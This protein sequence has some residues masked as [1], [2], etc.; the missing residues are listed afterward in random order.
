MVRMKWIRK[1]LLSL[2]VLGLMGWLAQPVSAQVLEEDEDSYLQRGFFFSVEYGPYFFV[3]RGRLSNVDLR[4]PQANIVG[5][6]GGVQI[7]YGITQHFSLEFLFLTTQMPGSPQYGGANGSYMFNLS[8]TIS[9]VRIQR[10]FLY[11]KIG[12][13]LQLTLPAETYGGSILGVSAHGGLGI[14]FY[15]RSNHLS[16]GLEALAIVHL[17]LTDKGIEV[18]VGFGLMPTL[19]YTF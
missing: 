12:G 3:A 5:S 2:L 17:P 7:G 19:L 18:A 11:A 10:L 13:G 9:F 6:F 8:S 1:W 4:Q 14:R 16:I 15:T